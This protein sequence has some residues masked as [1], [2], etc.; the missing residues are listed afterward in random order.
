MLQSSSSDVSK[1]AVAGN[2]E[3]ETMNQ[4][5]GFE[6]EVKSKYPF[7]LRQ[8][9]IDKSFSYD[10]ASSENYL[11]PQKGKVVILCPFDM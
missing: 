7:F 1:C 11:P 9:C 6:G 5:Y 3:S 2:H 4:M 10:M 8:F